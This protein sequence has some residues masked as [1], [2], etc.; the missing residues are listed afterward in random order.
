MIVALIL[1]G[2]VVLFGCTAFF[3]APYV[4]SHRAQVQR[5]F[6]DLRPLKRRDVLVDLGCGDG[7]VLRAAVSAGVGR[8]VG[9]ELNPVLGAIARLLSRHRAAVE[10]RIGNMWT[11]HPPQDTTVVY[12]FGVGRDMKKLETMLE[13]WSD[14]LHR[15]IDLILYGHTLP[16]RQPER[17]VGAHHLY[18]F[19]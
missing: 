14:E 8:A 19:S 16:G 13:S 4:P 3:G 1:A 6:R 5:A 15:P 9:I 7:V 11:A 2:I 10:V 17:T 18:N 12:V